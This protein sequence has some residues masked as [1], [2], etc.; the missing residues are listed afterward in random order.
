MVDQRLTLVGMNLIDHFGEDYAMRT[1]VDHVDDL[2][3][4]GNGRIYSA[5]CAG[6]QGG[7]AVVVEAILHP[8]RSDSGENLGNGRLNGRQPIHGKNAIILYDARGVA[9]PIDAQENRRRRVAHGAYGGTGK[10]RAP[11]RAVCRYYRNRG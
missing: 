2:A 9:L 11:K 8:N 10:P 6:C 1:D 3:V 4:K 5:W 7:P